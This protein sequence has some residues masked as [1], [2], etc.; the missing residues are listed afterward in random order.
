MKTSTPTEQ[1][2]AQEWIEYDEWRIICSRFGVSDTQCGDYERSARAFAVTTPYTNSEIVAAARR[3]VLEALMR[4][5]P[6][7]Q[8]AE[9]ALNAGFSRHLARMMEL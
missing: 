8:D 6:M 7:P 2:A 5:E 1:V 3:A 4:G 9:A